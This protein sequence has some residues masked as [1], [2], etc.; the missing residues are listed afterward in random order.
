[1]SRSAL[2]L[3]ELLHGQEP[4]RRLRDCYAGPQGLT[5]LPGHHCKNVLDGDQALGITRINV[6]DSKYGCY[7]A[8]DLRSVVDPTA[9]A[10]SELCLPAIASRKERGA[11]KEQVPEKEQEPTEADDVRDTDGSDIE[12]DSVEGVS[13]EA[14]EYQGKEGGLPGGV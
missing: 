9:R 8:T 5:P 12:N 11:E 3:P 13:S 4:R 1:M 7:W 6:P 10:P 2:R 14:E